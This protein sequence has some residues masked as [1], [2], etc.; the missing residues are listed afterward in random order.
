MFLG[1]VS[2]LHNRYASKVFAICKLRLNL[3]FQMCPHKRAF[4]LEHG[5]IGDDPNSGALYISCEHD[6]Y[7]TGSFI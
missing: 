4:V 3:A 7:R 5:I 2:T 6:S 1:E